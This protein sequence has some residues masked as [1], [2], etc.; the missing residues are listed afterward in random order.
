M[1]AEKT[2]VQ[3]ATKEL[4]KEYGKE[5]LQKTYEGSC[6][7]KGM[8]TKDLFMFFLGIKTKTDLPDREADD[9]GWVVSGTIY[10]DANSGKIVQKICTKE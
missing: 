4:I 8:A 9:H 10:I 6:I 1:L 7:A 2:L 5:Y 3:I